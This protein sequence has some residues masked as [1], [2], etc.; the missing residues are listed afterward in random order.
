MLTILDNFILKTQPEWKAIHDV[1]DKY[2]PYVKKCYIAAFKKLRESIN[3]DKLSESSIQLMDTSI[4]WS[5]FRTACEKNY[6]IIGRAILDSGTQ[7]S[8]YLSHQ[9]FWTR[10]QSVR[11]DS[12]GDGPKDAGA[13]HETFIV[14]EIISTA[15]IG[16]YEISAIGSFNVRNPKAVNWTID[17]VGGNIREV[18]EETRKAVRVIIEE[19]LKYGGHPYETAREIR[20]HIGLTERQT[21]SILN[22]Q[23][24]LDE[25]GRS[26]T[27]VDNMVDSQIRRMIRMRAETIART[28]TID[29]ANQGQ[30]LHW[31]DMA[32]KGYIDT[33]YIKKK[34]STTPDDR[35][36]PV[37][38]AISGEIADINQSFSWGGM[39]PT[40]H[41]KC[42]CSISLVEVKDNET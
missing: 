16:Q 8:F 33:R 21:M 31:E 35:L 25:S 42:R 30:L 29:A 27:R 24:K 19:A 28:E 4:D 37:C 39:R 23:R 26:Q 13:N 2:M 20:Q 32:E 3:I 36:C 9:N 7:A 18:E 34:W 40:R 12:T 1:A 5:V 15:T 38:M 17:Y 6:E 22:Y 11:K 41:P 10:N 14:P